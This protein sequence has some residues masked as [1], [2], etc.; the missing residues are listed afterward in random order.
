MATV[1]KGIKLS[2][3]A[4][5]GN[6][7]NHEGKTVKVKTLPHNVIL[8]SIICPAVFAAVTLT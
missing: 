6:M 8:N 4:L 5:L 2:E 3:D 1:E 7:Q